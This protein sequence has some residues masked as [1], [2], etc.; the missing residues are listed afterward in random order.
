MTYTVREANEQVITKVWSQP[1]ASPNSLAYGRPVTTVLQHTQ[2]GPSQWR[3]EVLSSDGDQGGAGM[4]QARNGESGWCYVPTARRLELL[5]FPTQDVGSFN[6]LALIL[7]NYNADGIRQDAVAGTKA[8][9]VEL[10]PKNPGRP[11]MRLWV[12]QE[13]FLP[14]RKELW[15]PE[16]R[17]LKVTQALDRPTPIRPGDYSALVAP[18][19]P[20]V[21]TVLWD[22]EYRLPQSSIEQS[23]GF[24]LAQM[25]D[26]PR[27]FVVV[28][29]YLKIAPDT[30]GACARW[31]LT[32]GIA[33]INVVQSRSSGPDVTGDVRDRTEKVRRGGYDFLVGGNVSRSEL[34]RIADDIQIA[35]G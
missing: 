28:G 25:P 17:L 21:S 12:D 23:V 1:G 10:R 15:G 7:N 24:P 5:T 32:D 18:Q 13:T 6:W 19:I 34:R 16:G 3:L 27:G 29:T 22:Q 20:G 8:W 26:L 2:C 33:T 11:M 9:F 30:V 14:L 4:I 31:E 35:G